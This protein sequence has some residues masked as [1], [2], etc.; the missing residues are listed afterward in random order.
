MERQKITPDEAYESLQQRI[1]AV[2]YNPAFS[3]DNIQQRISDFN[4]WPSKEMKIADLAPMEMFVR[5]VESV[6][7]FQ[8]A[9]SKTKA[10]NT[11]SYS[12]QLAREL[13]GQ[14]SG[15]DEAVKFFYEGTVF[16]EKA[17]IEL[18]EDL[19]KI[20]TRA[21]DERRFSHASSNIQLP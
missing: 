11:L 3:G 7:R 19:S 14:L 5:L 17:N 16:L 21:V 15:N 4:F 9:E 18:A 12:V 13:D 20:M 8:L 6:G 2:A 10:K 1:R